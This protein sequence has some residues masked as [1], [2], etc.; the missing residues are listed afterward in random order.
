MFT[1]VFAMAATFTP[2]ANKLPLLSRADQ[3]AIRTAVCGQPLVTHSP[4][5]DFRSE[6]VIPKSVLQTYRKNPPATLDLLARIA[7]GGS[8]ADSLNAASYAVGLVDGPAVGTVVADLFIAGSYD[9]LDETWG[10][11]PREHWVRVIRDMM[12]K[13]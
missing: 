10:C 4:D 5:R 3:A 6:V 1:I 8:A 7:D 11:S 12:P 9:A 2:I 13:K